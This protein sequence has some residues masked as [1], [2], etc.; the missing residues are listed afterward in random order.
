MTLLL[1]IAAAIATRLYVQHSPAEG[2]GASADAGA[3]QAAGPLH[4]LLAALG[5]KIRK[6]GRGPGAA[7]ASKVGRRAHMHLP[8]HTR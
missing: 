3:R 7:P 6:L 1:Q 5:I 2:P 8:P 4:R